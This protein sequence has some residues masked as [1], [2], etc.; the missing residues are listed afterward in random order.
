MNESNDNQITSSDP[1]PSDPPPTEKQGEMTDTSAEAAPVAVELENEE[2]GS[3]P[4]K[5]SSDSVETKTQEEASMSQPSEEQE[6][7]ETGENKEQEEKQLTIFDLDVDSLKVKEKRNYLLTLIT[8][9]GSDSDICERELAIIEGAA[10]RLNITL[11][12]SDLRTY[13]LEELVQGIRR[14]S[15]QQ[16]VFTDL[17]EMAKADRK[18]VR[19]ELRLLRFFAAR[20]G[21]PLPAIPGVQWHLYKKAEREE[22]EGWSVE[23]R[24]SFALRSKALRSVTPVFSLPWVFGSA[25]LQFVFFGIAFPPSLYFLNLQDQ[26][27]NDPKE[28]ATLVAVVVACFLTGFACGYFSKARLGSEPAVGVYLPSLLILG[29]LAQTITPGMFLASLVFSCVAGFWTWFGEQ[30]QDAR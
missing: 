29:F 24:K 19:E 16:A 7:S 28:F 8:L 1:A 9:A 11:R 20:W 14:L 27:V 3:E 18:L 2:S 25:I 26:R 17:I 30:M 15:L 10:Q 6:S 13:D 12:E 22:V 5:E 23:R 21:Q 4:C